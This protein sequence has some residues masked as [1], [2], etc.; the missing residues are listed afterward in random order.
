MTLLDTDV[1]IE[2]LRDR[3]DAVIWMESLRWS[4]SLDAGTNRKLSPYVV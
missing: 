3:P 2:Y 1:L 4:W